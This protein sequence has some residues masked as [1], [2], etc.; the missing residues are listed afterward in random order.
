MRAREALE[1]INRRPWIPWTGAWTDPSHDWID[2]TNTPIN[3][4]CELYD[5]DDERVGDGN[6]HTAA[7]AMALAWVLAPLITG[8]SQEA[9]RRGCFYLIKASRAVLLSH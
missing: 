5:P 4:G 1:K 7:E 8:R 3:R 6:G 9:R 2:Q